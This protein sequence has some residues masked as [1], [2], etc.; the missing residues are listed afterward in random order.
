MQLIYT[1]L[2]A[3]RN[4]D[5]EFDTVFVELTKGL[6]VPPAEPLHSAPFAPTE[7]SF[8]VGAPT[9]WKGDA[10]HPAPRRQIFITLQGEYEVTVL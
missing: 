8:W 9:N 7:G 2:F 4:G 5:S 6:A 3:G 10:A 1:R